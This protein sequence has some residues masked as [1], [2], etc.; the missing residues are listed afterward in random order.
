MKHNYEC[1]VENV[2]I[3][4][5]LFEEIEKIRKWRNDSNNTKYLKKIP[6]ITSEMQKKWFLDDLLDENCMTFAI[7]ET[8]QLRRLVGSMA[9]YNIKNDQVEVGKILVGD[10]EAHGKSVGTNAFKAAVKIAF[11]LLDKKKVILHVYANNVPAVK[12]Y[13]RAGFSIEDEYIVENEKEYLMSIKKCRG[14]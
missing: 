11:D 7:E 8:V 5:L 12:S 3:R 2:L 9:I 6:F 10:F 1:K 13:L 14:N 4:P